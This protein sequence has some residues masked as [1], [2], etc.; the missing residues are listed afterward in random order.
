MSPLLFLNKIKVRDE[1]DKRRL[2]KKIR[3]EE[4]DER[5]G[6]SGVGEVSSR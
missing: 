6:K 2:E 1:Y 4:R 5:R 3:E